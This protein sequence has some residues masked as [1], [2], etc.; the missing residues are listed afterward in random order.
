[1]SL[2]M[3]HILQLELFDYHSGFYFSINKYDYFRIGNNKFWD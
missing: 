1:M 2:S 3:N